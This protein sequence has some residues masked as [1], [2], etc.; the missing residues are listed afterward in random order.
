MFNKLNF[1]VLIFAVFLTPLISN[2]FWVCP[3]GQP[4]A[5]INQVNSWIENSRNNISNLQGQLNGSEY[6]IRTCWNNK[7]KA[8]RN[9][10]EVYVSLSTAKGVLTELNS[11]YYSYDSLYRIQKL[12]VDVINKAKE[13]IE[14]YLREVI[15]TLKRDILADGFAELNQLQSSLTNEYISNKNNSSKEALKIT[16]DLID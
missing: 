1:L 14:S 16:I 13:Q 8:A 6:N 15:I 9:K 12:Q 2:A 4:D 3:S 7:E 5:C 10:N 11:S